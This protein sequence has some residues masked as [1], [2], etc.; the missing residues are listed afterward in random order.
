MLSSPALLALLLLSS[1]LLSSSLFHPRAL[2]L[3]LTSALQKLLGLAGGG[4]PCACPF[5]SAD[6]SDVCDAWERR[7]RISEPRPSGAA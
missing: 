1:G 7:R 4:G 3:P 2:P 5:S 6:R